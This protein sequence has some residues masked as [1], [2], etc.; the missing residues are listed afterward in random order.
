[1]MDTYA[2][3]LDSARTRLRTLE[4]KTRD[5][6]DEHALPF[7]YNHLSRVELLAGRWELASRYVAQALAA[8][9]ETRQRPELGFVLA[10]RALVEAHLGREDEARA[11]L[12]DGFAVVASSD[13]VPASYELLAAAGFLELSLGNV[14][15]AHAV[16]DRLAFAA[17]KAGFGDPCV[18]R[19]HANAVEAAVALGRDDDA[20][21]LT[22]QLEDAGRPDRPWNLA[23]AG[24]SRGLLQASRGELAEADASLERTLLIHERLP[25]PFERARTLLA[26]GRVQRRSK[27]RG[28]ARR[29]LEAATALFE[30]LGAESWAN[31]ARSELARIGGRAAKTDALTPAERRVAALVVQG[32]SNK[33]VASTLFVSVHTVEVHLS[34]T[35]AKL[36][37]NSRVQLAARLSATS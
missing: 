27:K 3:D 10:T 4:S 22:R 36:G 15:E 25:E 29:T 18:F 11:S 12:E 32:L 16:F 6:G 7:V 17:S 9:V 21:T 13:T 31:Q 19:F 14:E 35:Y 5:R 8:A 2:G 20:A 1:M 26:H 30:E 28:D 33:E 34:R 24:R 23:S 37:I